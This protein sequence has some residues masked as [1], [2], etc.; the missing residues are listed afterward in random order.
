VE[1]PPSGRRLG[2][3]ELF[4]LLGRG[5]MGEVYRARQVGSDRWV[6]LKL[7]PA[8]AAL[9]EERCTRF[10]REGQIAAS[11]RHPHILTVH[12]AGV[13]EGRPYLAFDLVEGCRTFREAAPSL[14]RAAAVAAL[15]DVAQALGHAHTHGVVHRDVK[16]ENLLFDPDGRV[17]LADFGVALSVELERLTRTHAAVGT[18]LYMAPEVITE[19]REA[20]GPANDVYSLGVLLYETLTGEH[21]FADQGL[22]AFANPK[23]RDVR[24]LRELAQD[25]PRE[26]ERITLRALAPDPAARYPDGAALAH[27]LDAWLAGQQADSPRGSWLGAAMGLLALAGAVAVWALALAPSS[28]PAPAPP[29]PSAPATES[30]PPPP[31]DPDDATR[32]ARDERGERVAAAL[33]IVH[34]VPLDVPALL[35][36]LRTLV[37]TRQLTDPADGSPELANAVLELEPGSARAWLE[38]VELCEHLARAGCRPSDRRRAEAFVDEAFWS[39]RFYGA[40]DQAT[41]QRLLLALVALD[42]DLES[43]AIEALL[44]EDAPKGIE[45]DFAPGRSPEEDCLTLRF[46][47]TQYQPEAYAELRELGEDARLGPRTR[48]R[49]LAESYAPSRR[50]LPAGAL[51]HCRR[52]VELDPESA[53]THQRLGLAL[54]AEAQVEAGADAL[55]RGLQLWAKH[56]STRRATSAYRR[57]EFLDPVVP[58]L[59]RAGRL[60]AA[61]RAVDEVDA[62]GAF[63]SPSSDSKTNQWKQAMR[64]RI[65]RARQTGQ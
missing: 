35:G 22:A 13:V 54:L 38:A 25:V 53:W 63:E 37:A 52:A 6:A 57:R 51:P 58:G 42:V 60:D 16:P 15:R 1:P 28:G 47:R 26:L 65:D 50:G 5:G 8:N 61:Q 24:P 31:L 64:A 49:A 14:S 59:L 3:F 33:A 10:T 30:P 20:N 19:G 36:E 48:A 27:A 43:D 56:Y 21:P 39:R 34:V 12:S 62:R 41:Y 29:L 18:P 7:A 46:R 11:L 40:L 32:R 4:E 2:D 55:Q 44:S 23:V 45:P 17:R 9:S